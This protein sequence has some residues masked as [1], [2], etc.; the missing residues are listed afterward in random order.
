[1]SG[2][3]TGSLAVKNAYEFNSKPDFWLLVTRSGWLNSSRE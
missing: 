1:M 3:S 2:V